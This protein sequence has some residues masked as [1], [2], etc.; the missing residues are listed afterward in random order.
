MI[1]DNLVKEN[2]GYVNKDQIRES[3]SGT[4]VMHDADVTRGLQL[5]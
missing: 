4:S 2:S 5:G 3:Y 1:E